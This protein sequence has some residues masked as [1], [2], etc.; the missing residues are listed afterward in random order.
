MYSQIQLDSQLRN[1]DWET[2]TTLGVPRVFIVADNSVKHSLSLCPS[3]TTR[4]VISD[5]LYNPVSNI[6][7]KNFLSIFEW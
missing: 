4:V 1:N 2:L 3:Y 7:T 6:P 5:F